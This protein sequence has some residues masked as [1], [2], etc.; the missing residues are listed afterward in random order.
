MKPNSPFLI[1]ICLLAAALPAGAGPLVYVVN[2]SGQNGAGQFGTVDLATGAFQQIGT[3]GTEP[4]YFGLAPGANGSLVT[5]AYSSNLYSIN[6][7]T[8]AQTL[9]G[10]TGLADCAT[11][12]SPCGPTSNAS[13]G[14]LNGVIYATDFQNS[15]YK[16]NPV[17][18]AATLIGSTGIPGI[19]FIPG[20]LNQDGT[21][22]FYD[23]AVFGAGGKLYETFDVM[24]FDLATFSVV[25]IV[26]APKLYAIDPVTGKATLIGPTELGIGGATDVNGVVY[27]FNDLTAQIASL[28]LAN[29][30]TTPAG[31]F[32]P[33]AGVIQG[34][35][36]VTPE[37]AS[38]ALAAIGLA[39][40]AA[41][42]WRKHV[43]PIGMRYRFCAHLRSLGLRG[44]DQALHE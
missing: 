20:S 32:D 17:T 7:A 18:G 22:N 15:L 31:S 30:S 26:I 5:F 11:P 41:S 9:I 10:P 35:V 8:G 24:V 4:G 21:I 36:T 13:L 44:I 14:G 3:D 34:A 28:N 29:G 23:E 43:L 39:G 38:L 6:P 33:A 1:V 42:K 19:P 2:G 16:L 37:P 25:N 40:I 27:V 12:A